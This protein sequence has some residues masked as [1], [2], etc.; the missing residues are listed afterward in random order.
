MC[1]PDSGTRRTVVARV[2]ATSVG[3]M[4]GPVPTRDDVA[5]VVDF[6]CHVVLEPAVSAQTIRDTL[7][8][9][10]A[11]TAAAPPTL[12][13]LVV[14]AHA[15]AESWRQLRARG[16]HP[17]TAPA[18]TLAADPIEALSPAERT[19]LHLSVRAKLAP[20]DVAYVTDWSPRRAAA[21]FQSAAIMFKR[22]VTALALAVDP[23]SCPV[24]D[25]AVAA[26]GGILTRRDVSFLTM[27]AAE[28][29]I[30]V[31]LLRRAEQQALG[32]YERSVQPTDVE[33]DLVLADLQ[34]QPL[35]AREGT[36][37]R[38]GNLRRDG[39]PP[40]TDRFDRDPKIWLKRG[41]GFGAASVVLILLALSLLV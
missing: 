9:L 4:T 41:I 11:R 32:R 18:V 10:A 39:R 24:R 34:R 30:C 35:A 7:V 31:E 37:V 33:I 3:R 25:G 15:R 27:H 6:A 1:G 28:C 13:P 26:G 22:A 16:L 17:D 12:E 2:R 29:S 19:V 40:R 36:V 23:S 5:A 8:V 38:A 21:E 20:V 14:L